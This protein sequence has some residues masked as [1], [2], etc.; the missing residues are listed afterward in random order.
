MLGTTDLA[1][2][3]CA[4]GGMLV[5]LGLE[6]TM[7]GGFAAYGTGATAGTTPRGRTAGGGGETSTAA[8]GAGRLG[9]GGAIGTQVTAHALHKPCV[10]FRSWGAA[11]QP[12]GREEIE[13]FH[14]AS[15]EEL[16]LTTA[17]TVIC[18]EFPQP[19]HVMLGISISITSF[20][21]IV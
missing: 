19:M 21:V 4:G 14:V 13:A 11:F 18:A 6:S 15:P 3:L 7:M 9:G 16:S 12:G 20:M 8:D 10:G 1:T 5:V 2:A 17:F